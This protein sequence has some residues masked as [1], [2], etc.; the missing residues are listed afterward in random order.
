MFTYQLYY[1]HKKLDT[2]SLEIINNTIQKENIT[3]YVLI[4]NGIKIKDTRI[5]PF[6]K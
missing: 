4:K 1:N 6:K 2:E 5:N 3:E